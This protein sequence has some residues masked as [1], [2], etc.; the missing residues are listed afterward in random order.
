M[1]SAVC[2]LYII[3][4]MIGEVERSHEGVVGM[5]AFPG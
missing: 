5:G 1:V 3:I 4:T 2:A